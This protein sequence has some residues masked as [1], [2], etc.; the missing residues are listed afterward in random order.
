MS[1]SI[2]RVDEGELA[3]ALRKR[4][5]NRKNV[6]KHTSFNAFFTPKLR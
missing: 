4:E 2:L 5:G 3:I 1:E 6:W